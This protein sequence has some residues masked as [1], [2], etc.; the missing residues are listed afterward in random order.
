[1]RKPTICKVLCTGVQG[2]VMASHLEAA[3]ALIIR[4]AGLPEP[5]REY[6]FAQGRRYRFDF[7]WPAQRVAVEIEGGVW[8]GGR[9]TR[10]A[11]YES[12]CHK[13]NLAA[14]ERWHVLRYTGG[15]LDNPQEVIEQLGAL[16]SA[17]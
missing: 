11:G 10:G 4:A 16:L 3:F 12:D 14:V 7:A 17:G 6:R 9:H 13:Y 8:S 1:M 2:G 5:V 15:M